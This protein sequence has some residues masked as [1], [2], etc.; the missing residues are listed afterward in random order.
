MSC[1]QLTIVREMERMSADERI[2]HKTEPKKT[3]KLNLL[4]VSGFM[5]VFVVNQRR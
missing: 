4:G 3:P 2:E 1:G 5:N